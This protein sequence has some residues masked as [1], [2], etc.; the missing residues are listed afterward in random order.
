[1]TGTS[2]MPAALAALVAAMTLCSCGES[3]DSSSRVNGSVHVPAGRAAGPAD[4]VNGSIHIDPNAA[5]S[6][7]KTVNGG[8]TVGAQAT[9]DSLATVNG[10]ITIDP[11]AR[12]SGGVD[13]VNGAITLG[14][15]CAR[16]RVPREREWLH[17]AVHG[18]RER[19]HH[20]GKRQYRHSRR[21]ARRAWH[22]SGE[23]R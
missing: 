5:V 6:G 17:P 12:V 1:L 21:F 9:A 23:V 13:S 18:R 2:R 22:S 10:D 19:R 16:R 4:T 11:G 15:G 8:I 20:D 14:K 3:S 7:A